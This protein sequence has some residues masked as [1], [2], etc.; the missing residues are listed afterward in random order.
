MM[1]CIGQCGN[2]SLQVAFKS[3][4]LDVTSS[5]KVRQP[6]VEQ[7]VIASD[8]EKYFD[9]FWLSCEAGARLKSSC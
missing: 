4:I 2:T 6:I 1:D 9:N 7:S 3:E 5:V 8:S